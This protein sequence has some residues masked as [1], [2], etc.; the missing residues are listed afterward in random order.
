MDILEDT[1]HNG[2][3]VPKRS[4]IWEISGPRIRKV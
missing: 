3:L 1:I 2:T 4:K